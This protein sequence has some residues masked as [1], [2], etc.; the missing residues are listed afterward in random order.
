MHTEIDIVN[1]YKKVK[2]QRPIKTIS[3]ITDSNLQNVINLTNL[4]N[5]R[6]S[7]INIDEYMKCGIELWKGFSYSKFLNAKVI[8]KY[9]SNDKKYK[10]NSVT[11][12]KLEKS[13]EYLK[14]NNYISLSKYCDDK[15]DGICKPIYDYIHNDINR[16]LME[17]IL[18]NKM[19]KPNE[20]ELMYV[21]S[22]LQN[23]KDANQ[24]VKSFGRYIK[25]MES[26]LMTKK[27]DKPYMDKP[28]KKEQIKDQLIYGDGETVE[29]KEK[30]E[31]EYKEKMLNE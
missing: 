16:I 5:T 8:K 3:K 7:N 4:F 1:A 2:N 12:E 15:V 27:N 11:R 13:F 18:L 19:I 20:I 22:L 6:W 25:K 29:E 21:S 10:R 17:Y 28:Q 14:N 9:I 24:R 26:L 30:K 31:K 23:K